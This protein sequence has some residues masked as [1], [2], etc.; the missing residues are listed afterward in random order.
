M[1][2]I[3]HEINDEEEERDSAYLILQQLKST[4]TCKYEIHSCKL[5]KSLFSNTRPSRK[6]INGRVCLK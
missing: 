2:I 1:Y 4:R 3:Y 5:A 6:I